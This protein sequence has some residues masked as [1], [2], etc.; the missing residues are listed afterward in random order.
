MHG[1]AQ[2]TDEDMFQSFLMAIQQE[3]ARIL[4]ETP[5]ALGS[6]DV[7]VFGFESVKKIAARL[8][9]EPSQHMH[10]NERRGPANVDE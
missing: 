6:W 2:A 1:E 3:N 9:A 7:S 8:G 10:S 4:V 5:N